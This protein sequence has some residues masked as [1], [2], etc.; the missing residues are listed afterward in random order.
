M[1]SLVHH[2]LTISLCIEFLACTRSKA[3]G[4]KSGDISDA[5]ISASSQLDNNTVAA[6]GRYTYKQCGNKQ[7]AW[8]ALT[9]DLNQWLQVDLRGDDI[10]ITMVGTQGRNGGDPRQKQFVTT[11]KLQ[12]SD[13]GENFKYYKEPGEL[14]ENVSSLCHGESTF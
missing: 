3:L 6:Q 11:Y 1:V 10:K 13:D 14:K 8:S 5:Q 9:N 7:G 2:Y 4:M 12:Y